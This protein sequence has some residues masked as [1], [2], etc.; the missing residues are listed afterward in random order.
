M[1]LYNPAVTT[2]QA[3]ARQRHLIDPGLADTYLLNFRSTS[4]IMESWMSAPIRLRFRAA[5]GIPWPGRRSW[6]GGRWR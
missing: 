5:G 1:D 2:R 4:V 6:A 3:A